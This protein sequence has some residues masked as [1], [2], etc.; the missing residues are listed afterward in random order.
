MEGYVHPDFGLVTEKLNQLMSKRSARGGAAV[1][2]Y[3]HGELVVDAWTGV[4]DAA[5]TP[6]DRDTMS[7][8]FS[9]TKG[10]VAT[11][12]HRL[13]DRGELAYDEP[14]AR[15]W[16]EFATAG[17]EHITIRQVL[18]HRAGLHPVRTLTDSTDDAC[19]IGSR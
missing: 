13:A 6:W 18:T 2:V 1:A 5:G 19:S 16:P 14:V 4:R 3:H 15:Y 12:A 10:V 17:K 8:S 11:V 9:T 7:M